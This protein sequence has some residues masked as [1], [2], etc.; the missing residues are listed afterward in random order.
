MRYDVHFSVTGVYYEVLQDVPIVRVTTTSHPLI[1]N[2]DKKHH[3]QFD[4][5]AMQ[6]TTM[7]HRKPKSKCNTNSVK[8]CTALYL[9]EISRPMIRINECTSNRIG[10]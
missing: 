8:M 2:N 1:S 10:D 5:I 4:K 9:L 3:S 7:L 6:S